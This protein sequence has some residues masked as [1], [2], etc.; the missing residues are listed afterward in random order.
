MDGFLN[1]IISIL[2]TIPIISLFLLYIIIRIFIDNK[3]KSIVLT[4]DIS[5][6][7][8]IISVHFHFITI[9]KQS[10]LLFILLGIGCLLLFVYFVEYRKSKSPSIKK[11]TRNTWRL[12]FLLFVTSYI[13]LTVIGFTSGVIK[14]I[15]PL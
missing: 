13:V 7:F 8:F 12:S 2:I 15:F 4:I 3:R 10:F 5:T 1:W 9:F 11:I 6:I 14:N